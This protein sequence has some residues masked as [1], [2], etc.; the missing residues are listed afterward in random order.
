VG[1]A[2]AAADAGA[3]PDAATDA[4]DDAGPDASDDDA[5][6]TPPPFTPLYRLAVRIHAGESALTDEQ[7]TAVTAEVNQIW[8]AQAGVCFEFELVDHDELGPGFDIWYRAGESGDPNGY[9][10]G[11]NDIFSRDE[12][13][14]GAAPNPVQIPT[15]RTTAH[16]FGHGLGLSHQDFGNACPDGNGNLNCDDLLMR[17]G[18]RGFFLSEPEIETARG[19]AEDKALADTTPLDCGPL[20][21]ER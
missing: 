7:F 9:Y 19:R 1:G 12:P 14:L 6:V 17:S 4:G 16:E 15:A 5:S 2:G 8:R 11:D 3:E 13:S 20:V 21:I 18:R 10:S